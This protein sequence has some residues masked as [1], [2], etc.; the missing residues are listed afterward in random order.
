MLNVARSVAK[1][2]RE[3]VP[4]YFEATPASPA[5]HPHVDWKAYGRVRASAES[6]GFR[7]LGDIDP[8]SVSLDPS[9]FK[10]TVIATYVSADGTE[11]LGHYR[12]V[13]RWTLKGLIARS[14]VGNADYFDIDTSFGGAEGVQLATTTASASGV[15]GSP[16]FILREVLAKGTSLADALARHRA[17]VTKYRA[18]RPDAQVTVVR[19]LE[20]VMANADVT[21]R[22]K[23]AWREAFGWASRDEIARVSKLTG[24]PL[25][26]LYA[27]FRQH[28]N[29]EPP[30]QPALPL[31][32]SPTAASETPATAG[33]SPRHSLQFDRV[34]LGE[35]SPRASAATM[36]CAS[37]TDPISDQYFDVDGRSVCATCKERA[38]RENEPARGAGTFFK[39]LFRGGIAALIGAAIYYGVIAITNLEIGLVALVIGVMVGGAVRSGTGGKGGRKFQVMAVALTYFAVGLAYTPIFIIEAVKASK[40]NSTA[41]ADSL[42]RRDDDSVARGADSVPAPVIRAPTGPPVIQERSSAVALAGVPDRLPSDSTTI[43][44]RTA[45]LGLGIAVVGAIL[46]AFV[47]PILTVLSTLPSGLISAFIIGFGMMQAWK[48]TAA[49]V[50]T[51][52]GPYRVADAATGS[53]P[54]PATG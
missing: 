16:S 2:V 38:V 53:A 50:H 45:F 21:E 47:L 44:A 14:S 39:A 36:A 10:R 26:E 28:I 13:P 8:I 33:S 49:A 30:P 32:A 43:D 54:T 20:D 34:D 18:G 40:S 15:W 51:V 12:L 17:R 6:L 19:T 52:S 9:I 27:S 29:E 5:T 42:T 24:P 3:M 22:R 41:I 4:G 48:M 37:C 46:M 25:D 1:A 35:A 31:P 7:H 23:R 11:V